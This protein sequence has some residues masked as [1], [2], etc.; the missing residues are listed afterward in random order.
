MGSGL[1]HPLLRAAERM[2]VSRSRP[3]SAPRLFILGLPRSGT[4]LVY[5]YIVHRLKVAYLTNGVGRFPYAPCLT[6]WFQ[7]RT[8]RRYRSDFASSY[9]KVRG[10]MAPR[11]A[12]GFWGQYFDPDS[13]QSADDIPAAAADELRQTVS[14]IQQIHGGVPFV[15]K[16]VKHMQRLGALDGIFGGAHF[17]MVARPPADV[18]LSVLRAR[19]QVQDD[20]SRWWSVRPPDDD[21]EELRGLSPAGQVAGQLRS[22]GRRLKE[23]LGRLPEERVLRLEYESFCATPDSVVDLLAPALGELQ[24]ANPPVRGFDLVHHRPRNV[25]EEELLA[26]VEHE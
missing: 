3:V 26:M 9:G 13:Y 11:E 20:P 21:F 24:P 1:V 10:A 2:F 25:E 7:T 5:Q 23:D 22:L 14:C 15:N 12:G 8:H 19:H 16:N 4:T 18:A 17:L 6:T